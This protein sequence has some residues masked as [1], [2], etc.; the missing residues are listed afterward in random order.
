MSDAVSEEEMTWIFIKTNP[1]LYGGL[2][3]LPPCNT[4]HVNLLMIRSYEK[5][6]TN[7]REMSTNFLIPS[8]VYILHHSCRKVMIVMIIEIIKMKFRMCL[9]CGGRKMTVWSLDVTNDRI[10]S[11]NRYCQLKGTHIWRVPAYPWPVS[12]LF[13]SAVIFMQNQLPSC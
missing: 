3:C 12:D 4:H 10:D 5:K 8:R 2:S 7:I 1:G 9:N 11:V 13:I 6:K